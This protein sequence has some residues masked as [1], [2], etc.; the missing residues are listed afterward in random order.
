M[1]HPSG[2]AA[3][4]PAAAHVVAAV[5][6]CCEGS[7]DDVVAVVQPG[8]V[9]GGTH[10]HEVRQH[11]ARHVHT[12]REIHMP[13][14]GKGAVTEQSTANNMRLMFK[15]QSPSFRVL[16]AQTKVRGK[17]HKDR[18]LAWGLSVAPPR[19]RSE[20]NK[21]LI[22]GDCS[23]SNT[24]LKWS[25]HLKEYSDQVSDHRIKYWPRNGHLKASNGGGFLL[26]EKP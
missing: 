10:R 8:F 4:P 25:C 19:P 18:G 14:P 1:T 26:M 11:T 16:L 24:W 9:E 22:Q 5:R 13:Q 7:V 15:E 2:P 20:P 21:T 12:A 17:C 3:E 6:G 23:Y